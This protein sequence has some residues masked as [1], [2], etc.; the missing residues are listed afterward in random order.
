MA[1]AVVD[2][3]PITVV[4]EPNPTEPDPI[5]IE[6]L[7]AAASVSARKVY[8]SHGL[9]WILFNHCA[10]MGVS[11]YDLGGVDPLK[12]KGVFDFKKGTGAHLINYLGE[13]EYGSFPTLKYLVNC[14][15]YVKKRL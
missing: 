6:L 14:M 7:F 3:L 13:W 9:L 10:E 8:A 15:M 11:R 4:F 5:T 2:E 1:V 12:N